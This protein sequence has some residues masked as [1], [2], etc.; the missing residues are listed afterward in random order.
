MGGGGSLR[1]LSLN[2]TTVMVILLLGLW[3]LLGC[4]NMQTEGFQQDMI[5]TVPISYDWN[6]F[7]LILIR[8]LIN[9]SY[10]IDIVDILG[11]FG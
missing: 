4:T 5:K 10:E 2:P 1:L 8:Y 6:S 9:H 11:I 7:A 3:L